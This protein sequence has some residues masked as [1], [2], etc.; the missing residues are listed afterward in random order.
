MASL[1]VADA[2]SGR[3]H[4]L[5]AAGVALLVAAVAVVVVDR[6]LVRRAGAVAARLGGGEL[7]QAAETRLRFLRRSI[8]AAIILVGV[9]IA[10]SNVTALGRVAQAVL[11]S[12]AIAAAVIGFAA[13]Q[14]LANA[15]AGLMLAVAQPLRIGDVVTFEEH[16]GIVEDIG[17]TYT[18][19]R[20]S[21]DARIIVPNERLAT[22]VL[23]NDTIVVPTVA[24]EASIWV[25]RDT[26]P[27]GA[28][29]RLRGRLG[30]SVAVGLA[31]TTPEGARVLLAGPAA[32]PTERAAAES[33]LR[34]AALRALREG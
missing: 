3:S 23:R 20:T 32:A 13:R 30:D 29:D 31:E 26:E 4:D 17:L 6:L 10:L 16:T 33:A 2:G 25:H 28:V 1:I 9:A 11:A 24:V 27:V 22:G 8:D 12:S 34:E 7:S 14:T 21:S 19:L 18:W 15:I 5:I